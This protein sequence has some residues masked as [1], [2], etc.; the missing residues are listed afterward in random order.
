[1]N[2]DII[3]EK[4]RVLCLENGIPFEI[5]TCLLK[6]DEKIL[7]SPLYNLKQFSSEN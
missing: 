6:E 5:H 7:K 4:Y 3:I 1:M 2:I